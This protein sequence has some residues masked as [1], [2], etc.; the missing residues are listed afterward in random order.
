M[1]HR[2]QFLR[3]VSRTNENMPAELREARLR[4]V[5]D[6]RRRDRFKSTY[7][8]GAQSPYVLYAIAA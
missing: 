5:G 6:P 8:L 1:R 2:N 3:D 4:N 7:E